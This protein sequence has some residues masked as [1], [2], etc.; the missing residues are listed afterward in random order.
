[1]L[2]AGDIGGTKTH[3]A[4]YS[5][6]ATP[7][8]QQEAIFKSADYPSLE[9]IVQEFLAQTAV[10]VKQAAFGVAGPVVNG[11]SKITNLPWHITE[12]NLCQTL[13]LSPGAV[14]LLND[15]ESIAYA[16]PHLSA[17]DLSPLNSEQLDPTLGG[18]K[19]VIA[20]GTGLGEAILFHHHNRYH[21][22]PSEGGHTDFGPVNAVQMGLLRFLLD[23]FNHVSYERVCSGGLGIPNIYAYFKETRPNEESPTVRAALAQSPDPTPVIIQ[24]GLNNEC[25][26]CRATLNTFVSILGAEA[27]NLALKVMATGGIYLGGGIPRKILAKLRDG[28]F[29]AAFVNKGRFAGL[30]SHIPVYIILHENPGLLGAAYYGLTLDENSHQ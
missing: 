21:V 5:L 25:E 20:P 22:M 9:A 14:K 6:D 23:R 16:V 11:E 28:T 24:A 10:T 8:Q 1:M 4:L 29:M 2:L 12:S 27:G 19:A 7:I 18:H 30:L 13:Q 3:L 15:L 26:L 17:A